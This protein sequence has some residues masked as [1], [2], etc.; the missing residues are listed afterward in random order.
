VGGSKDCLGMMRR[1]QPE[2]SGVGSVRLFFLL[3]S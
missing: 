1:A 3:S 2:N